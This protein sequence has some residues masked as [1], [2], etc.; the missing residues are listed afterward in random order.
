MTLKIVEQPAGTFHAQLDSVCEGLR[1]LPVSVTYH[2][3]EIKLALNGIG[4]SF[5][6][7]LDNGST[8][9]GTWTIGSG[10]SFQVTFK[11]IDPRAEAM[12]EM[13][14]S[15]GYTYPDELQG[16]WK[17]VL[18][19]DRNGN[20]GQLHLAVDIARM[21]DGSFSGSLDSPDELLKGVAASSVQFSP[22]HVRV[23]WIGIG[24]RFEGKLK[25]GK[26]SGT[27]HA[28]GQGPLGSPTLMVFERSGP[29]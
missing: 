13:R 11:S 28:G 24:A 23:E 2:Q 17:G 15:Y 12:W 1:T 29:K 3:P 25:N 10:Q 21:P 26:L 22:P 20:K 4:A 16:H 5:E 8:I 6:G 18:S 14:K 19:A 27:W 9:S 7:N